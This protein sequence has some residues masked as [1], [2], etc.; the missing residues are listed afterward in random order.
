MS[1]I[2]HN[3]FVLQGGKKAIIRIQYRPVGALSCVK[4]LSAFFN[5]KFEI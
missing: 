2:E 1:G 5:R 4:M 3:E